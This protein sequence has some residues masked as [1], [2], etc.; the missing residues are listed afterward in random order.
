[1]CFEFNYR[2]ESVILTYV[3]EYPAL[4]QDWLT[5]EESVHFAAALR[6]SR[7]LKPRDLEARVYQV[8]RDLGLLH[9]QRSAIRVSHSGSGISGPSPMLLNDP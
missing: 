1:M 3:C 7:K 5:V 4:V 2:V 6:L 8:I 9:V